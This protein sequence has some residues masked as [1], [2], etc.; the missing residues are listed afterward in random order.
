MGKT[1]T[2]KRKGLLKKLDKIQL[3]DKERM[4]AMEY[5]ACNYNATEAARR[6]GY[7]NPGV[8]GCNVLKKPHVQHAIRTFETDTL[9]KVGIRAEDVLLQLYYLISRDAG[10]FCDDEGKIVTDVHRLNPRARACIDGIKQKVTTHT[11]EDG[12]ITEEITTELKL[13]PKSVAVDMGMKHKGLFS[14]ELLG[15]MGAEESKEV[16]DFKQL[17][18]LRRRRSDEKPKITVEI[19][20]MEQQNGSSTNGKSKEDCL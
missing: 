7:S 20:A 2:M 5:L 16:F 8:A 19:E 18:E 1:K 14:P 12:S 13:T 15:V 4:F 11:S 6:V 9:A 3:T 17:A 10:D